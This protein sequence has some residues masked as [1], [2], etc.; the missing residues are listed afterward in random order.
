MPICD[1]TMYVVLYKKCVSDK[2]R[3]CGFLKK[4]DV[5]FDTVPFFSRNYSKQFDI[6]T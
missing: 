3:S 2:Y 6:S 1:K 4:F 5:L